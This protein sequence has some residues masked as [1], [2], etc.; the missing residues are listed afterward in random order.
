MGDSVHQVWFMPWAG[1]TSEVR[2]GEALFWPFAEC[3]EEYVPDEGVRR[4]LEEYFSFYVDY[5]GHPVDT[6]AVCT[7]GASDFRQLTETETDSLQR[8]SNALLF[9]MI[10]PAVTRAVCAGN[11]SMGPPSSD[12]YQLIGQNF[13]VGSRLISVRA[14]STTVA[15]FRIGEITFAQPFFLGGAFPARDEELLQGLNRLTNS[16]G[17]PGLAERV[18]RSMEWF[19]LAHTEVDSVS[20]LSK[21]V[22]M[23]TAFEVVLQV[24][25]RPDKKGWIATRLDELCATWKMRRS[26]RSLPTKKDPARKIEH[27]DLAWWAYGFYDIR[28]SIVHGD[29]IGLERLRYTAGPCGGWLSQLMVA[30]LVYWEC[31]LR[32]LYG[33]RLIGDNVRECAQVYEQNIPGSSLEGCEQGLVPWFLGF[34][35]VHKALGWTNPEADPNAE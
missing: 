14:G 18:F 3:T 2:I 16:E 17:D 10:A 27:T 31:V 21:I 33:S 7:C 23:G 8:A 29:E 25:N 26:T 5:E 32:L 15:G 4:Y 22:M 6:V 13:E 28:N 9:S 11:R 19:R 20:T 12:R 24:P 35:K 34:N 1:L 30:D